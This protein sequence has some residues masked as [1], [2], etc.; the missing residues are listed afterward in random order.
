M[1]TAVA[2][3]T[4]TDNRFERSD[5]NLCGNTPRYRERELGL[6]HAGTDGDA[7][8]QYKGHV[9]DVQSYPSHC[10]GRPNTCKHAEFLDSLPSIVA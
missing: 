5:R 1:S 9:T 6:L 8:V 3:V 4:F 2:A 10:G 7:R